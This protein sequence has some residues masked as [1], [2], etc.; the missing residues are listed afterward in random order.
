M[1]FLHH[2]FW[3]PLPPNKRSLLKDP[4]EDLL[5]VFLLQVCITLVLCKVLAKL[6]SFIHQPAVIGQ[7]LAGIIL[8][9]SGFG[10]IPGFS[11]FLFAEHT[12]NSLQLVAS[13]GLIFFMFYLGLKMDPNEI[14]DGWKRTVPIASVSII[15]PVGI[16]C[17]VSL[18][19]YRMAP[20][21]ISKVAFILF[22]G[23]NESFVHVAIET[24]SVVQVPAL[25]FPHFLF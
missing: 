7:I 1:H 23:R 2:G 18:W 5:A 25:V 13:L 19:L 15:V 8:G 17:G 24:N 14:K 22:I 20:P 10:F 3:Q 12:L 21:G 6:L 9:P 16:G 4:R 11:S